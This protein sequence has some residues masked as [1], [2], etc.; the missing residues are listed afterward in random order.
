M[1]HFDSLFFVAAIVVGA[2]L[3]CA[4]D[5]LGDAI[6][7]I[8]QPYIDAEVVAG[9]SIVVSKDR[10]ISEV[11]LG[12]TG[13]NGALPT[14]NSIYEIGSVTKVFTGL[15]LADAVSRGEL[16]LA[17]PVSDLLPAEVSAPKS[18]RPIT[19]LD[20][21]THR[22]GLPRDASNM[23]VSQ[24]DNP[25]A[26]YD[27]RLALDFFEDHQLR[28]QPGTSWEYSNVGMALLGHLVCQ[29]AGKSYDELLRER[30]TEPLMMADT[31]AKLSKQ[32]ARR[33]ATPHVTATT[34]TSSWEF[35]DIPGAGG[36]RSTTRD[37]MRLVEACIRPPEGEVGKA[38]TLSFRSHGEG[39]VAGVGSG[40]AW[41]FGH[42]GSTRWHNGQTGGFHSMVIINPT[43]DFGLVLL[44]NTGT[45]EVDRLAMDVVKLANGKQVKPRR[46]EKP[47]KI[48]F[49]AKELDRLV[50]KY[51]LAPNVFVSV[52]RNG[53]KLMVG[54]TNQARIEV[55]PRNETEWFYR[56]LKAMLKFS[57]N[58]DG[59]ATSIEIHQNGTR[60][61]AEKVK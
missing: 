3:S 50:G 4:D 29:N 34:Q 7:E 22:S 46:F 12:T 44:A 56:S 18:K 6:R 48:K 37:M 58:G 13:E 28:R 55:F 24:V 54:L 39:G 41:Q 15:L 26:D 31:V 19:L 11:H 35:A 40:L 36:L 5:H 1:R 38:I 20:L 16:T 2:S 49:T 59:Q 17:T 61:T 32:Q 25:F 60:Q 30:I 53:T 23:P 42:D 51:E 33:F 27:S 8:A 10:K 14:G 47:A 21:A 57:I 52:S 45:M 43:D 9:I